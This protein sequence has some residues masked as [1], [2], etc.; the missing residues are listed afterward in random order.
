MNAELEYLPKERAGVYKVLRIDSAE[1][2]KANVLTIFLDN[3]W[4]FEAWEEDGVKVV[5]FSDGFYRVNKFLI[6]TAWATKAFT[7]TIG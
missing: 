4:I 2:F 6:E 5:K 7:V 1:Y 3:G